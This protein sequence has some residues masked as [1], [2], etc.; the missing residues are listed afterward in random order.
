MDNHDRDIERE[1]EGGNESVEIINESFNPD[2]DINDSVNQSC[3]FN[4]ND[5]GEKTHPFLLSWRE[6]HSLSKS[7]FLDS[8][9]SIEILTSYHPNRRDTNSPNKITVGLSNRKKFRKNP[10]NYYTQQNILKSPSNSPQTKE[11][12]SKVQTYKINSGKSKNNQ[13]L[14]CIQNKISHSIG[15]QNKK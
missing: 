3:N 2:F 4:D 7:K 8:M 5:I 15:N 12:S 1:E 10:S 6:S 14:N 9:L 13:N 11:I